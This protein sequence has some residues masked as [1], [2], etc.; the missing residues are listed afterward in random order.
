MPESFGQETRQSRE[1]AIFHKIDQ[2]IVTYVHENNHNLQGWSQVEPKPALKNPER[3]KV[4]LRD[5]A[6]Q[7]IAN[8]Q[9]PEIFLHAG[10]MA[11]LAALET[12]FQGEYEVIGG[13]NS[14]INCAMY[15]LEQ[16]GV[17]SDLQLT[18]SKAEVLKVI[19]ENFNKVTSQ[20]RGGQLPLEVGELVL[21]EE[22]GEDGWHVATVERVGAD[23]KFRSKL[24]Q[25]FIVRNDDL[26]DLSRLYR[27]R[28]LTLY[29]RK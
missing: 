7:L 27:G 6:R 21:I 2:M 11:E 19:Q 15:S 12:V 28:A 3:L 18:S 26:D 25:L 10:V 22:D 29:K 13:V 24:G 23:F 4:I 17:K 9:Q 16:L 20:T 8:G 14:E 1:L 5:Y